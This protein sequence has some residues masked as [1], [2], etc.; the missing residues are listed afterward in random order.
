MANPR[1]YVYQF[2]TGAQ[3]A[4]G[5]SVESYLRR[6]LDVDFAQSLRAD[7]L[8]ALTGFLD[9]AFQLAHSLGWSGTSRESPQMFSLP[10]MPVD[11][12]IY[13]VAWEQEDGVAYIA[14]PFQLPWLDAKASRTT[15]SSRAVLVENGRGPGT[16]VGRPQP[17]E[18]TSASVR[19]DARDPFA[20][21]M[22]RDDATRM[23]R[24]PAAISED[25]GGRRFF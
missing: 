18:V 1:V 25:E 22:R 9:E 5:D 19:E 4:A 12:E 7:R 10:G 6:L 23:T 11:E 24:E 2:A 14:S 3:W 17:L 16:P 8:A 20:D 13:M 21:F 15:D